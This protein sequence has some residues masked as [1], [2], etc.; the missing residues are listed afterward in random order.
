MVF[1]RHRRSSGTP[2]PVALV[3]FQDT[4]SL[5]RMLSRSL[6]VL[7]LVLLVFSAPLNAQADSAREDSTSTPSLEECEVRYQAF[8]YAHRAAYGDIDHRDDYHTEAFARDSKAMQAAIHSLFECHRYSHQ[9]RSYRYSYLVAWD[10]V[11][12]Y[13]NDRF[14]LAI[15]KAKAFEDHW[16]ST[17]R[18]YPND[19]LCQIMAWGHA[20]YRR[21][22]NE[23]AGIAFLETAIK[24][25]DGAKTERLVEVFD[26]YIFALARQ[27]KFHRANVAGRLALSMLKNDDADPEFLY[28]IRSALSVSELYELAG[29]SQERLI[30]PEDIDET[31][32][33][34][35]EARRAATEGDDADPYLD[36]VLAFAQALQGNT[37]RAMRSVEQAISRADSL[38]RTY[39]SMVN[40]KVAAQIALLA[41]DG[42]KALSF[43]D[44]VYANEHYI[45]GKLGR[46]EVE[47]LRG[48]A[49]ALT[50]QYPRAVLSMW[51]LYQMRGQASKPSIELVSKA[52]I[53]TTSLLPWGIGS[54][55][56][57]LMSLS[58]LVLGVVR[59]PRY[60]RRITPWF[61]LPAHTRAPTPSSGADS[62]DPTDRLPDAAAT[63]G[64]GALA[65]DR[66][67][68][69]TPH[70]PTFSDLLDEPTRR[71]LEQDPASARALHLLN[72]T[73]GEAEHLLQNVALTMP[74]EGALPPAV[75]LTLRPGACD[76]L[77][78]DA[79]RPNPVAHYQCELTGK[80]FGIPGNEPYPAVVFTMADDENAPEPHA[81]VLHPEILDGGPDA[82]LRAVAILGASRMLEGLD[83]LRD[84][85]AVDSALWNA[86][87]L[88][89]HW[90]RV[91]DW[92]EA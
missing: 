77:H 63:V 25:V 59:G 68:H 47:E 36:G 80:P 1:C 64:D 2:R 58:L 14:R 82:V 90:P 45:D 92:T 10:I 22:G 27:K 55:L 71:V 15:K 46:Y 50:G 7:A 86:D 74:H 49:Y 87:L 57:I 91:P 4:I 60:V 41:E 24:H 52:T 69:L 33:L 56:V 72:V 66:I 35:L 17:D 3:S 9:K 16:Y 11:T 54:G 44:R 43:L 53:G 5:H 83:G 12:D 20:A 21:L 51:R 31:R 84:G 28:D 73:T 81:L 85:I 39:L 34:L 8:K 48:R 29:K 79:D 26:R 37:R 88:D 65:T 23:N 75:R 76:P 62:H 89:T 70:T 18:L 67:L 42:E 32:R 78:V 40:L 19:D 38:D 13:K 6:P 30:R 61:P